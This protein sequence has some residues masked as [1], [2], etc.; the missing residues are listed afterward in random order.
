M[1]GRGWVKKWLRPGR[2]YL[3]RATLPHSPKKLPHFRDK[4]FR[5][6]ERGE[7]RFF[8][9]VDMAPGTFASVTP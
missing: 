9:L 8:V 7:V 4:E 6:L 3:V 1:S 5:L 2:R